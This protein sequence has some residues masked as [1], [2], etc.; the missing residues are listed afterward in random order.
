MAEKRQFPAFANPTKMGRLLRRW[1]RRGGLAL[2]L[3]LALGNSFGGYLGA[4]FTVTKGERLIRI[5]LNVVL[6]AFIAKL[7]L[8][9]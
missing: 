8:G 5:V 7:L 4:H 1:V 3:A 9:V 6:V 2:G